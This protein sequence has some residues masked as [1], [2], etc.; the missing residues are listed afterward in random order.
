MSR[1]RAEWSRACS[2]SGVPVMISSLGTQSSCIASRR[3]RLLPPLPLPPRPA[4]VRYNV[5]PGGMS[6]Q[7]HASHRGQGRHHG[8]VRPQLPTAGSTDRTFRFHPVSRLSATCF[9]GGKTHLRVR[10]RNAADPGGAAAWRTACRRLTEEPLPQQMADV[11]GMHAHRRHWRLPER[12][13][14]AGWWSALRELCLPRQEVCAFVVGWVAVEQRGHVVDEQPACMR[15]ADPKPRSAVPQFLDAD[16]E[17]GG[18][19]GTGNQ[20]GVEHRQ[21]RSRG[22]TLRGGWSR[23]CG[24]L[25]HRD[26]LS[27]RGLARCPRLQ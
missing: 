15:F 4:T 17:A 25:S 5:L 23:A 22:R 18:G 11:C 24:Q 1:S 19:H 6:R 13:E 9:G 12:V 7:P 20:Y 26:C 2:S 27:G 8:P 3:S 16:T 10:A 14:L 21:V